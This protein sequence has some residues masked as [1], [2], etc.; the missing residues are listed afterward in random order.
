[1]RRICPIF[2]PPRRIFTVMSSG[3]V[4]SPSTLIRPPAVI[5]NVVPS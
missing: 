2:V 1:M 3:G 4:P 5:L